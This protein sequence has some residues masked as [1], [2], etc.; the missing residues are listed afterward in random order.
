MK[1][2]FDQLNL[3]ENE[4]ATMNPFLTKRFIITEAFFKAQCVNTSLLLPLITLHIV[5][6][7]H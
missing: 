7:Y 3:N 4:P 5:R 2:Q 1:R 6:A